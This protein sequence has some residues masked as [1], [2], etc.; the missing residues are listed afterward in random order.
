MCGVTM[1]SLLW[2]PATRHPFYMAA[3]TFHRTAT[4]FYPF[5]GWPAIS[6]FFSHFMDPRNCELGTGWG[7]FADIDQSS[8]WHF[9][10]AI[11]STFT[12]SFPFPQKNCLHLLSTWPS[13]CKPAWTSNPYANTPLRT[14]SQMGLPTPMV[15]FNKLTRP[16]IRN[17]LVTLSE[18]K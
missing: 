18:M 12:K 9:H 7:Y 16:A 8:S 1:H 13:I 6:S 11:P 5:H 2:H 4:P 17:Q 15:V 10:T 3:I 14:P